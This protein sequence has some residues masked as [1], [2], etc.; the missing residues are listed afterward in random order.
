VFGDRPVRTGQAV[1]SPVGDE[2]GVC[3]FLAPVAPLALK[4]NGEF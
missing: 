3:V 2:G 4:A 1:R